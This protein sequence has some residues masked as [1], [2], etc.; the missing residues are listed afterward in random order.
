MEL[1]ID[2]NYLF[3]PIDDPDYDRPI[4]P[5]LLLAYDLKEDQILAG[6]VL[7]IE[8]DEMES[9]VSIFFHMIEEFGIPKK[10]YARNPRIL[11]GVEY[12]C[13]QL[14]IELVNDPLQELDDIYQ[15]IQNT[16]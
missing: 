6:D 16:I 12:L 5:L 9:V 3:T 1:V 15:N 4:N 7:P 10:L 11:I 8:Q 13:E 2:L 14:Q